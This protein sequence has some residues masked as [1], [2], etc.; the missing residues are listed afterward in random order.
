MNDRDSRDSGS[1]ARAAAVEDVAEGEAFVIVALGRSDAR[2][3]AVLLAR[4]S[5]AS[6][7]GGGMERLAVNSFPKKP[8][9]CSGR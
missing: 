9:S 4:T 2:P 6:R 7:V 8:S 5:K 1:A 3:E